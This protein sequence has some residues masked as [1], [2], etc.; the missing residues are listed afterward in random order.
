[1]IE[2]TGKDGTDERIEHILTA[3][4]YLPENDLLLIEMRFFENRPFKEIAD[5]M[6]ITENNAKVRVYRVIDKIKEKVL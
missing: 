2:E 3:L 1:M 4:K 5:I 6:K